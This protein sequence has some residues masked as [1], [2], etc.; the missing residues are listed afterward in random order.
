MPAAALAF[1]AAAA[2]PGSAAAPPSG[3]SH[4]VSTGAGRGCGRGGS[5]RGKRFYERPDARSRLGLSGAS[6][7]PEPGE[8]RSRHR[9]CLHWTIPGLRAPGSCSCRPANVAAAKMAAGRSVSHGGGAGRGAAAVTVFGREDARLPLGGW[10]GNGRASIL[11]HPSRRLLKVD[12]M[13]LGPRAPRSPTRIAFTSYASRGKRWTSQ[14]GSPLMGLA[15][16]FLCRLLT[17]SSSSVA[18]TDKDIFE[19][20]TFL[21]S[22]KAPHHERDELPEQRGVGGGLD[23][24]LRP[25]GFGG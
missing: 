8:G 14:T 15:L 19:F 17:A 3:L 11:C 9:G 6:G 4:G 24:P 1:A 13:A 21:E 20:S 12:A 16:R 7:V 10:L 25:V 5:P 2:A 18:V 23:V 22:S